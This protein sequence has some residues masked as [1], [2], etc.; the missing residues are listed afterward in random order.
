MA[1]HE[2]ALGTELSQALERLGRERLRGLVLASGRSG[3]G[4]AEQRSSELE[5]GARFVPGENDRLG[6]EL[7]R[8][9][10]LPDL[11]EET[12]L[13]GEKSDLPAGVGRR[14]IVRSGKRSRAWRRGRP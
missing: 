8:P 13:L 1:G 7:F 10:E 9:W 6:Q 5:L 12:A 4:E 3:L 14:A 2:V 11:F